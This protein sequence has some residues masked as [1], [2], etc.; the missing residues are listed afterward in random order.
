MGKS[1]SRTTQTTQ[2]EP[3]SGAQ[4]L[5]QDI[6]SQAQ[7]MGVDGF[8]VDPYQGVRVAALSPTTMGGIDRLAGTADNQITPAVESA[9][10]DM[11][12][13]DAGVYRDFDVIRDRVADDVQQNLSGMFSGGGL[14]SGLA[15][16]T[17]GR[18]MAEGIAGVEYGAY[19]DAQNRRLGA[20]GMAPTIAGLG[21]GDAAAML[22]AGGIL[23]DHAQ[24][25]IAGDMSRYYEEENA[26]MA[27]LRDYA[28]IGMGLG[29]LGGTNS[30]TGPGR[31][32][33][34]TIAGAG[35]QGLGTYGALAGMGLG[36]P[37]A[38]G[39]GILAGLAG[40]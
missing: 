16:D 35:A 23:D 15:Q 14:N 1:R 17:F 13:D 37:L 28:G 2:M 9:Y 22:T 11:I 20:L 3:W 36:G 29:G 39:G 31:S 27:A 21:R 4:P 34:S 38:I 10:L 12:Q 18:A 40:L 25:E 5:L 6:A 26:D 19:N 8:R 7:G 33:L 24:R 32:P 30:M